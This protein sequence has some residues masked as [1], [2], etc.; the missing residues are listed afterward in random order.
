MTT[1]FSCSKLDDDDAWLLM[2]HSVRH[3]ITGTVRTADEAEFQN[4]TIVDLF[5]RRELPHSMSQLRQDKYLYFPVPLANRTWLYHEDFRQQLTLDKDENAMIKAALGR[6]AIDAPAPSGRWSPLITLAPLAVGVA[7]ADDMIMLLLSLVAVLGAQLCSEWSNSVYWY[8]YLRPATFAPR[9]VFYVLLLAR[10]GG[11]VGEANG[12]NMLGWFVALAMMGAD[13]LLGDLRMFLTVGLLASWEI[14][15]CLPKRLFVCKRH[16]AMFYEQRFGSRGNVPE[17]VVGFAP[18]A[19]DF[20]L[21]ADLRGVLVELRPL[22]D[23]AWE[24][25]FGQ[26]GEEEHIGVM[27]LD[28]FSKELPTLMHV[29]EEAKKKSTPVS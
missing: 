8:Q 6:K 3:P 23:E 14:T 12:L 11:A 27:G 25:L 20:A 9:L 22:T 7:L 2:G 28:V 21:I 1:R 18:W 5:T 16:G 10:L 17:E 13:I 4:F 24:L 26:S 19:S 29:Q 15:H